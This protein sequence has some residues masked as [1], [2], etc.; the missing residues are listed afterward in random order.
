[1]S[2][3]KWAE[4]GWLRSH[5]PSAREMSDLLAIVQRDLKDA[6]GR[7][8]STDWKFGIAY[9]AALKLCTILLHASGDRAEK[10]LAHYR[11]LQAFPLILGNARKAE[12]AGHIAKFLLFS[13]QMGGTRLLPFTRTSSFFCCAKRC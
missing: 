4:N 7:D 3:P 11:T 8:I 9:N 5:K 12:K 1:M 6:E 2:L 13:D 10:A